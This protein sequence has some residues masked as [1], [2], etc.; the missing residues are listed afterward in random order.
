MYMAHYYLLFH[1]QFGEALIY[2]YSANNMLRHGLQFCIIVGVLL[3]V[4]AP[5]GG[6]RSIVVNAS[7]YKFFS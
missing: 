1:L 7:T 4:L 6:L 2:M 3:T 5:I